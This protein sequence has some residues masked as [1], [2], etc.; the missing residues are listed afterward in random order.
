MSLKL[1]F[2][3]LLDAAPLLVA[4]ERGFFA[5][6]GLD[7]ELQRQSSWAALRDKLAVGALDGAQ[8]LA[9]M[10]LASTLGLGGLKEPLVAALALNLGGNSITLSGTLAARLKETGSLA[11]AIEGRPVTFGIV[12]PFSSHHYEMRLW[13]AAAGI[14]AER[15]VTLTVVPPAQMLS[16][17]SAGV[18]DGYCVGE[19]W[20]HLAARSGLGQVVITSRE[21]WAGRIE[22]VYAVRQDWAD[23]NPDT[24]RAVLRALLLAA[25]WCDQPENRAELAELLSRPGHVNAPLPLLRVLLEGEDRPVF[26]QHAANFPWR[27]QALWYLAQMRRWGQIEAP[28]DGFRLVDQV[29]RADLAR[30]A[31][32]D[33]GLPVPLVDSKIEGAHDA[34]WILDAAS[35]PI[36]MAADRFFDQTVFD[37]AAIDAGASLPHSQTGAP[38]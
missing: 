17:L 33:L 12:H 14:D 36:A 1:G 7:V 6:Q 16:N 20:G 23:R 15:D 24:H 27:S 11:A 37:P 22:K 38:A 10:V 25:R 21:I 9:P 34:P 32:L 2:L 5:E 3:A 19:P 26:H 8:M 13:L 18:I 28:V 29:F 31:F 30:L 35:A 4:K